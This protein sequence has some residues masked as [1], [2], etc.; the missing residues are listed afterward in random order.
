MLLS[1]KRLRGRDKLTFGIENEDEAKKSYNHNTGDTLPKRTFFGLTKQEQK[2][3]AES[4][5]KK[6][7]KPATVR[8]ARQERE[9]TLREAIEALTLRAE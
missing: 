6:T 5:K 4:L 8:E 9:L 3:I 2:Q 1:I 7:D